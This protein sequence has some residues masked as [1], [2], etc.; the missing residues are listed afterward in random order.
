MNSIASMAKTPEKPRPSAQSLALTAAINASR[1]TKAAIAEQV[2]VSAGMVSQWASGH[3]P[4][5]AGKARKLAEVLGVKDPKR[6]SAAFAEVAENER[7]NV[8]P[9][10]Q[11]SD[12]PL[13]PELVIARLQNDVDALRYGMAALVATMTFHRPSEAEAAAKAIRRNVPA[14]FRDQGFLAELLAVLDRA[15]KP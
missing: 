4:V 5:P 7:S 8:V 2:G 3:R 15:P 9:L 12:Q 6:I 10:R 13:R 1:I 14:K 11:V